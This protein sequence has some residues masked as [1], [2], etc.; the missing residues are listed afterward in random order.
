M[1]TQRRDWRFE[2]MRLLAMLFI[3]VTHFL[4]NDDLTI[5]TDSKLSGTWLCALHDTTGMFGQIGVSWFVLISSYFLSIRANRMH[6]RILKLWIQVEVFSICILALVA[7]LKYTD[8]FVSF[9]RIIFTP[10]VLLTAVFPVLF[11][12]YW[13]ISA[14]VVMMLF[15]PFINVVLDSMN[16]SQVMVLA[17]MV[18]FVTF[19]WK[20]IN[21]AMNYFT[22]W[23][24]LCSVYL[25]GAII[26]RY[27]D[28]LPKYGFAAVVMISAVC[29]IACTI[30]THTV[31]NSDLV[32]VSLGYP[33]NIATAGGG[34]SPLLSVI[35]A[36]VSFL[37]IERRCR[38]TLPSEGV[39]GQ[40][41]LLSSP[42]TLGIYL[43]HENPLLKTIFWPLF[44]GFVRAHR[45]SFA[46]VM[47][48]GILMIYFGALLISLLINHILVVPL[49]SDVL[50]IVN[51]DDGKRAQLND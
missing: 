33:I 9:E 49:T 22:D 13:F 51:R 40:I 3:V 12:E 48:V 29:F 14:F 31:R 41:V 34:A 8:L 27:A 11:G 37:Y 4:A 50:R 32:R 25:I 42:A 20:F 39:I 45:L 19:I 21:P 35:V 47:P 6:I 18:V 2:C 23:G 24:Y 17:W 16:R 10:R 44:F 43:L 1:G 7:L 15:A 46:I 38:K 30:V 36:V 26:R 28:T 5:H